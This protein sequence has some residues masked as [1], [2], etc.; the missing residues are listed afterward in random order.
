MDSATLDALRCDHL[1]NLYKPFNRSW[2]HLRER[3][4]GKLYAYNSLGFRGDD[5]DGDAAIRIA[6]FG[7]SHS[8]GVGLDLEETFAYKLKI[9]V[10]EALKVSPT[11]VKVLNFSVAGNSNDVCVRY[12]VKYSPVFRPD[13]VIFNLTHATRK[14]HVSARAQSITVGELNELALAYFD[15]YT[16][17]LGF[18]Y[19]AKNIMLA[20]YFLRS[21]EVPF[22]VY[23]GTC[24][25]HSFT[26]PGQCA[27]F[28]RA[29]DFSVIFEHPHLRN[30]PDR[31][32]DRV[33]MGSVTHTA[34]AVELL[35]HI[36]QILERTGKT[37]WAR[38]IAD[39]AKQ[40]AATSPE[41]R[42]CVMVHD[43][44]RIGS[45]AFRKLLDANSTEP[46]AFL[47]LAALLAREKKHED[48]IIAV[49]QAIAQKGDYY[50]CYH[51]L[52]IL[53]A[54]LGRSQEAIAAAEKA[55]A[56]RFDCPEYKLGL[57]E[58]L[59]AAEKLEQALLSLTRLAEEEPKVRGVWNQR[60]IALA[61]L[62]R[63]DEAILAARH[64]CTDMPGTA[65]VHLRLGMLLARNGK[66]DLAEAP[67]AR[68]IAIG[69]NNAVA[70]RQLSEVL[71][72]L[73]RIEEAIA[74]AQKAIALAPDE[75][76]YKS[77]LAALLDTR[78]AA[79][80]TETMSLDP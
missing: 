8:F 63:I 57:A 20:H 40:K 35:G 66:L 16:D 29:L 50:R 2:T 19:T 79:H 64:A 4:G 17:Q 55:V 10:A 24:D 30:R 15:F 72:G 56:L 13:L 12:I 73:G 52:S 51:L 3:S 1:R 75:I 43:R 6:I 58:R 77:H 61:G 37:T 26:T 25:L 67:L 74:A 22:L 7:C 54:S 33:H 14:E 27:D 70:Y 31:A 32:A 5:V 39:T 60:S 21:L 59:I 18:I 36:G 41:Y 68:A 23:N 28:L 53:L 62:G 49:H 42:Y 38:A 65:S 9:Y 44:G 48:A 80:Q 46:D 69:K 71:E 76:G 45:S 78:Q 11:L 34:M 47:F